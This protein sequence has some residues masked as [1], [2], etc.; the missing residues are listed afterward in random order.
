MHNNTQTYNTLT[1]ANWKRAATSRRHISMAHKYHG[2]FFSI[3]WWDEGKEK[4][5]AQRSGERSI[6]ELQSSWDLHL[7]RVINNFIKE[8]LKRSFVIG[9]IHRQRSK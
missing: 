7:K 3:S 5:I 6:E 2:C 9:A 1:L 4:E 8:Y